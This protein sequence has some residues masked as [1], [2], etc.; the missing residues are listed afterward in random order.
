MK[1]I[2][3]LTVSLFLVSCGGE[4]GKD[5]V[6]KNQANIVSIEKA[7]QSLVKNQI[8][9][10]VR[11]FLTA[12]TDFKNQATEF[13]GTKVAG[14][15]T[16][17][18]AKFKTLSTSWHR[19]EMFNFGPINDDV[20]SPKTDAIYYAINNAKINTTR[21]F[22]DGNL[23]TISDINFSSQGPRKR[24]L[25]MLEVL[26]F[27]TAVSKNQQKNKIVEDYINNAGKCY[28]LKG[29]ASL[30]ESDAQYIDDGWNIQHRA[31]TK[32][33]KEIYLS[34]TLINSSSSLITLLKE[35]QVYL[36]Y[37]KARSVITKTA[38]LSGISY[39]NASAVVE[40]VDDLLNGSGGE[41]SFFA[42]MKE[43]GNEDS[44]NMVKA[45]IATAKQALLDKDA[46]TFSATM[47]Q[48]DG[49]FKRQIASALDVSL[50]LNFSDGD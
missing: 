19:I 22:V 30:M 8:L 20:F 13:C 7:Q 6:E 17:L 39:D 9:P 45:N 33:F 11:A 34:G 48:L 4:R 18:Q 49:N 2:L 1:K 15:L 27:E 46:D 32:P 14:K 28:L 12:S 41:D 29:F 3:V 40:A 42:I 37:I 16:E 44:V 26:L 36:D 35:I 24:G 50:G 31:S 38:T 25:L 5:T 21:T 23:S 43:T 10:D 47:G